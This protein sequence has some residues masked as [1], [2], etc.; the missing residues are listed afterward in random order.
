MAKAK[1]IK[2]KP[3]KRKPKAKPADDAPEGPAVRAWAD[4]PRLPGFVHAAPSTA[5]AKQAA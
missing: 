1:E 2:A 5:S 3:A 4:E